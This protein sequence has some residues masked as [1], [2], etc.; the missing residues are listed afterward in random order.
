MTRR[1]SD[2]PILSHVF[3]SSSVPERS[4]QKKSSM[5]I[6]ACQFDL[7]I[8][9]QPLVHPLPISFAKPSLKPCMTISPLTCPPAAAI[10]TAPLRQSHSRLLLDPPAP[11]C[12]S[13]DFRRGTPVPPDAAVLLPE[14]LP[15]INI[16]LRE[17]P[18]V[19]FIGDI[20]GDGNCDCVGTSWIAFLRVVRRSSPLLGLLSVERAV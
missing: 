7:S 11:L 1:A 8:H 9:Q 2:S 17:K 6:S 13:V 20:D 14:T 12:L 10:F 4:Q 16:K 19:I 15:P 18:A 3:K 5:G